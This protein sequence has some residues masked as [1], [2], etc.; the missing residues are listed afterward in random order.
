MTNLATD[1]YDFSQWVSLNSTVTQAGDTDP[2]GGTSAWRLAGDATNGEH[3]IRLNNTFLGATEQSNFALYV[4][5]GT[6]RYIGFSRRGLAEG[7]ENGRLYA[8]HPSHEPWPNG[9]L[10]LTRQTHG[11]GRGCPHRSQ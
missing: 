6:G 3:S 9:T 7:L 5:E 1:P 10:G 11:H 2:D 8:F 4:K